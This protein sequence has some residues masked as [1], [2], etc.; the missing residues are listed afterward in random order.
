MATPFRIIFMGTPNFAVPSLKA[1]LA[2][3]DQVVAVVTQPD[4]PRG[5]GR[6]LS[7]SP[8]KELA[9]AHDLPVLQP[10]RLKTQEFLDEIAAFKPDLIAVTAYGRILPGQILNL[11]PHGTI[12]VHGS[13]L[14]KY[15]GAAPIQ[16]A[17]LN[18]ETESGVTIM[19]MDEGLDTGAIILPGAMAIE[20]DDTSATLAAKL[21]ELGGKLLLTT[22]DLLHNGPLPK[23]DQ[24]DRLATLAPP[25]TKDQGSIDWHRS[26]AEISCL[27]RGLDPWPTATTTLDN[28]QLRLFTPL[29]IDH[30]V[31]EQ[32][33]TICRADQ[34]GLL[35]ATSQGYLLA[36]EMQLAGSRRMAVAD[37]LRGR[38]VP[39][40]THLGA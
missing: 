16:W 7:P 24:D 5:R 36:K 32:P 19:Q 35:I 14:P 12:N 23:I 27:I 1:L 28:I 8:V 29:V 10:I 17:I 25:L 30:P 4:R 9:L 21:S 11:P 40:R 39:A 6:K 37:F 2:G 13:L 26:A 15:R 31:Q 34:E 33:G 3:P 38:D 18:G 22:L 20:V